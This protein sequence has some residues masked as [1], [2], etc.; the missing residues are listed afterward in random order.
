MNV[1]KIFNKQQVLTIPNL[2][3]LIRILLIPV[4]VWLY[5]GVKNNLFCFVLIVISG[6]LDVLDGKIARRYNMISDVGKF[7]D[8]ISDKL[9]QF[10]IAICLCSRYELMLLLVG[11]FVIKEFVMFMMG[12][13]AAK[14]DSINGAKWHGK[15]TTAMLYI[16][17]MILL[18]FENIDGLVSN[19]LIGTT[20]IMM[21]VSLFLYVNFYFKLYKELRDTES[22]QIK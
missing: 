10:S 4:I 1:K 19:I 13:N 11:V 14:H 20:L 9:T 12:L 22:L 3:C 6:F 17:T 16:M 5:C 2:L 15:L 18:V 7:L 8:P 21:I